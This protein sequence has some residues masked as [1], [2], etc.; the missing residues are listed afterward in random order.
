MMASSTVPMMRGIT[1][2]CDR[3]GCHNRAT[4]RVFHWTDATV[5]PADLDLELCDPCAKA[6]IAKGAIYLGRVP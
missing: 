4:S 1:N 3:S 5:A 6:E 2:P